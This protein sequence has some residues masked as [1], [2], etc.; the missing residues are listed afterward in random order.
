MFE[1]RGF[2]RYFLTFCT[3]GRCPVFFGHEAVGA[4]LSLI[5]QC[6]EREQFALVAHCFMPDHAHL[7]VRGLSPASDLRRCVHDAKQRSGYYFRRRTGRMLWQAGYYDHVLRDEEESLPV[8]RYIM[9]NPVRAG[10]ATGMGEYPFCSSDEY[11]TE[12]VIECLQLWTPRDRF[13][14]RCAE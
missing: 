4:I 6:A 3:A 9:E 7:L 12:A 8:V 5:R 13:E 14:D 2:Y 11:S 1:Y 10:L